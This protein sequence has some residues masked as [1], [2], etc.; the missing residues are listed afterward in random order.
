MKKRL[1]VIAAMLALGLSPL[2]Y[3]DSIITSST[4]YRDVEMIG[5]ADGQLKF[6]TAAGVEQSIDYGRV[7]VVEADASPQLGCADDSVKR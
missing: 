5:F 4:P 1:S 3:A 7:L 6:L 2:T